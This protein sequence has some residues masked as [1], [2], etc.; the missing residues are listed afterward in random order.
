MYIFKDGKKQAFR[1]LKKSSTNTLVSR[2]LWC[3]TTYQFLGCESIYVFWNGVWVSVVGEC[4]YLE[5]VSCTDDGLC[6]TCDT[7]CNEP[8]CN[9]TYDENCAACEAFLLPLPIIPILSISSINEAKNW[10]KDNNDITDLVKDPCAKQVYENL[11]K[12]NGNFLYNTIKGFL[13]EKPVI[14][15][16]WTISPTTY[17]NAYGQNL[18]NPGEFKSVITMNQN[19]LSTASPT[20]VAAVMIHEAMHAE[21]ARKIQSI[22]GVA[23][24][25]E[26][27]F[28]T[29]F[30]Y[31]TNSLDPD[32]NYLADHYVAMFVAA[33]KEFDTAS[34]IPL[35]TDDEYLSMVWGGLQGTDAFQALPEEQRDNLTALVAL[36]INK[37][38]CPN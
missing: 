3:T 13:G 28:P 12:A 10:T 15:L 4:H 9:D 19:F 38:G 7:G 33:L 37:G 18:Y 6:S 2:D 21:I 5:D 1:R 35:H 24:L 29:L 36:E 16:K 23:N 11:T 34:G 8:Y 25:S 31:Y 26:Q 20:M 32:H 30:N 27:N 17:Q 22:G 14:H